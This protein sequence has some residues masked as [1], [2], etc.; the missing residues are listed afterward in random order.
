MKLDLLDTGDLNKII[1]AI[2]A[3]TAKANPVATFKAIL[4]YVAGI[5]TNKAKRDERR[6]CFDVPDR[7]EYAGPGQ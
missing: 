1:T 7:I 2:R 3:Q 6:S 4:I 5:P